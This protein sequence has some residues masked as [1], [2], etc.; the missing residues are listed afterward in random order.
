MPN[1]IK[2]KIN[3]TEITSSP[4]KSKRS[5]VREKILK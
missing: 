1:K 2:N 3:I 5:D 4:S